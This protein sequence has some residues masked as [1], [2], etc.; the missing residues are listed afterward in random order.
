MEELDNVRINYVENTDDVATF[1]R[2]LSERREWL[3]FDS[4]TSGLSPYKDQLRLCQFGDFDAGWAMRWDRWAGVVLEAL[5][6]YQDPIVLQNAKF[7]IQFVEQ[8]SGEKVFDWSQVHD[9]RVMAHLLQPHKRTSLKSLG[10]EF[11]SPQAKKLQS[12][13]SV[14][15]DK[16]GWGWGD[17]PHDW[18]IYW[19]YGVV[20]TILTAR[21]ADKFWPEVST[22]YKAVYELEMASQ[23]I[24]SNMEVRG[25]Q[26][27][28][29]YCEMMYAKLAD[30][31][32]E[33]EHY[34]L[35]QWGIRPSENQAVGRKLREL[36]I[37]MPDETPTGDIAVG[38][39]YLEPVKHPLAKAVLE[40]R[41]KSKVLNS[42]FKN[43]L[44]MHVNGRMH[45]SINILAARTGRMS[46]TSPAL[47]TIPRGTVVRDCFLPNPEQSMYSI[48]YAGIEA[49]LFAH[50]ADEKGLIQVFK[51]GF[52]PHTYT[53][54]QV[55]QV[56][57]PTKEQR[58]IA[59]SA[60]FAMLFGAGPD[61]VAL[62]AGVS[63]GEAEAFLNAYKVRFPGV[64]HFMNAVI[65]TS[66]QR[67]ALEGLGYVRTP[68]G[69]LEV[70]DGDKHYVLINA[71]IQGTAADVLKNALVQLDNA[72]YGENLLLPIHD[73]L[74]LSLPDDIPATEVQAIME[75]HS[76]FRVPLV[77]DTDGPLTRW[78]DCYREV[79]ERPDATQ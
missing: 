49:R 30:Y 56:D 38:K 1:L 7:D 16:N 57:T 71:L 29:P 73:E 50:F 19:G 52:D 47:Q 69:R 75:D 21:I 46:V 18:P 66:R 79:S 22:S 32:R 77:C 27:D 63:R 51:N 9:T 70:A 14:A 40:H 11:L 35:T 17:I 67:E 41:Q 61:K 10:A 54:Q 39:Q 42:Y 72:G 65:Q 8:A 76:T 23:R 3:A 34:C 13:L 58:Q 25:F 26:I 43:F 68:L 64:A 15:M 6:K 74:L 24:C 12:A 78:G 28:L 62:T 2:W 5:R 4:E 59:K 31:C 37:E 36:G 33:L 53:A 55:Y 48:D 20:D 45:P 44:E 60:T